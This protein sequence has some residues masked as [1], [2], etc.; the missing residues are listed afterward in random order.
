MGLGFR[1]CWLLILS[2]PGTVIVARLHLLCHLSRGGHGGLCHLSSHCL[3]YAGRSFG[4]ARPVGQICVSVTQWASLRGRPELFLTACDNEGLSFLGC[5]W[6]KLRLLGRTASSVPSL[7]T[8]LV[9]MA[10]SYKADWYEV[11]KR[12]IDLES[13]ENRYTFKDLDL[14]YLKG[15]F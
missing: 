6:E 3:A 13:R 7:G 4:T 8:R 1:A 10:K 5:L 12:L 2:L 11:T 15:I 14:E 9:S